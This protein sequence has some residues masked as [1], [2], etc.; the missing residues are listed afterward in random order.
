MTAV[1]PLFQPPR[2]LCEPPQHGAALCR[3]AAAQPGR[4]CNNSR[5]GTTL[6]LTKGS[7]LAE[8][9]S[10]SNPRG[11]TLER[12]LKHR[13]GINHRNRAGRRQDRRTTPSN[14]AHCSRY[15]VTVFLLCK[16]TPSLSYKRRRPAPLQREDTQTRTEIDTQIRGRPGEKRSLPTHTLAHGIGACLNQ[17]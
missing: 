9:S 13:H 11:P 14:S 6:E 5:T 7:H 3:P 1:I 17:F 16:P 2:S 12:S 10:S 15:Q 8:A 4:C